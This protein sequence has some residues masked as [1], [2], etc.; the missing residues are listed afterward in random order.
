MLGVKESIKTG[1]L[2]QDILH[3][4]LRFVYDEEIMEML[5][6]N[7]IKKLDKKTDFKLKLIDIDF[8]MDCIIPKHCIDSINNAKSIGIKDFYVAV[9]EKEEIRLNDPVI[10][11]I[12]NLG[13]HHHPT[14]NIE[15]EH[16]QIY[17]DKFEMDES[18]E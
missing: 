13:K 15:F 4:K 11:G 5:G 6:Y 9:L 1:I 3:A 8:Y 14:K 10:I 7:E 16:H 18:Y 2:G 17:I 12:V